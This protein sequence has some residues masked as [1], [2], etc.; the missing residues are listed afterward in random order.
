[1]FALSDTTSARYIQSASMCRRRPVDRNL[2]VPVSTVSYV[3]E[4]GGVGVAPVSDRVLDELAN[5]L[6]DRIDQLLD[7]LTDR[8]MAAPTPG[9]RGWE[10]VWNERNTV[11]GRARARELARVRDELTRRA[12]AELD[13]KHARALGT[14]GRYPPVA[15]TR[16]T[17]TGRGRVDT[18]Q[19]AFF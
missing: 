13:S 2:S 15:R 11:S 12:V 17:K 3:S 1:M 8:A 18:A 4:S 5:V 7:R 19:L 9:S 10:S 14:P 6:V 16:A